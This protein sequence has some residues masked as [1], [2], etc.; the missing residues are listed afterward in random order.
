MAVAVLIEGETS[1]PLLK[2]H[3]NNDVHGVKAKVVSEHNKVSTQNKFDALSEIGENGNDEGK[4]QEEVESAEQLGAANKKVMPTAKIV[5]VQQ[6][7]EI[8]IVTTQTSNKEEN[9]QEV[10]S[11][12]IKDTEQ[13]PVE[14]EQDGCRDVNLK[15]DCSDSV[16]DSSNHERADMM[17]GG[18]ILDTTIR[19]AENDA[20]LLLKQPDIS[21]NCALEHEDAVVI[22]ENITPLSVTVPKKVSPNKMLHDLVSHNINMVGKNIDSGQKVNNKEEGRVACSVIKENIS[23]NSKSTAKSS[24]KG[25]KKGSKQANMENQPVIRVM[26]K[27]AT[28]KSNNIGV[29]VVLD[30]DQEV[31]LKLFFH[32]FNQPIVTSVVYAKCD[33]SDRLELWDS[34][35]NLANTVTIPWIVGGDF[36]V[37]LNQEEKIGGLPVDMNN[38]EDFSFCINSYELEEVNFKG[39]PFT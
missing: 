13:V 31:T 12:L 4:R 30:T 14:V 23:N 2:Q 17:K 15:D 27:R 33:A 19:D 18:D 9:K 35:Y 38:A 28:A 25:A 22:Y 20:L 36:N 3:N 24:T 34:I 39:S 11:D 7:E 21:E 8:P 29:E 37:V 1:V 32:E 5:R 10:K 6:C 16:E 26:P